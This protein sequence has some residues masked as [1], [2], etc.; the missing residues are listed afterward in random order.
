[1]SVTIYKLVTLL[2]VIRMLFLILSGEYTI[3][4]I[5]TDTLQT[6]QEFE[7]I[8]IVFYIHNF[9]QLCSIYTIIILFYTIV[10]CD[11]THTIH[12]NIILAHVFYLLNDF[13]QWFLM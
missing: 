8:D 7:D 11:S 13:P 10:K 4:Y 1:V 9:I 5:V 6:S 12:N 2:N 3:L